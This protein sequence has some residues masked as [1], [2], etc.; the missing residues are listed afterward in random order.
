[1]SIH[2]PHEEVISACQQYRALLEVAEAIVSHRDLPALFHDLAG[3]LHRVVRFDYLALILRDD[4]TSTMRLHVLETSE[5]VPHPSTKPSLPEE[6]DPGWWVWQ[7]QQPLILSSLEEDLGWVRFWERVK[8]YR[9]SS[10][11]GL[12]LTTARRRL[13]VLAFASK[14]PAAYDDADVDFLQRVAK[15]VAVAV[16][17]ALAFQQ[18]EELKEK[19]EKEKVYLEEE[20]RTDHNFEE[21]VGNSNVLRRVL[22]EVE[23]VAP[24][25]STVLIRGETGTGKE[26]VARAIHNLNHRRDRTFVKLNC[27]A[28]PTGLLESELFGHEKGAFTGAIAQKLG[29]FE[30]AHQGT[31]FLD[32]VGDIPPELQPK[33]L[34]VLQEQEFERLGGTRTIKVDVR[35]VAAT[36]RDLEQMVA[37][38]HF[39]SDLYYRLNVFPV[40]LP[41]LRERRD[42]IA[43]LVRHFIQKFARRMGRRIETIPAEAMEALVSYPWPGNIRELE[44]V[45]ERAVILSGGPAL[46]LPAGEWT[47]PVSAP[48]LGNGKKVEESDSGPVTL[49]DAER[50]HILDTLQKANWV[51]GGA[52][53]AAARLGMKRSTLQWKMKK[54]TISRP[55]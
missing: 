25:D 50:E 27:A 15:Q 24:T 30:L 1:M 34:R 51:L 47:N 54:L 14:Q 53:G 46:R 10:H 8:P 12:P 33:L 39:R 5:T 48:H 26:L 17:N 31:L 20:I 55:T 3:P 23:T 4:S 49:A 22:Q 32:E 7:N 28:I 36:H 2:P 21:I 11:C 19:L 18:I 45:I 40:L 13:G 42:D 6:D 29:R 9:V 44:N 41:P 52:N 38:G 37:D 16:E 43:R 35:L